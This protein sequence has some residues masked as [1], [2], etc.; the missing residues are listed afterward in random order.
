MRKTWLRIAK[1][2]LAAF[3]ICGGVVVMNVAWIGWDQASAFLRFLTTLNAGMCG[4]HLSSMIFALQHW[5][6]S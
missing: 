3:I 4:W 6:R 2:N 5:M 1:L